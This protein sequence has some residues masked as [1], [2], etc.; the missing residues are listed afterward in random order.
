MSPDQW[1]DRFDGPTVERATSAFLGAVADFFPRSRVGAA[2]K[3]N[4]PGML[5]KMDAE[6]IRTM[7]LGRGSAG[8][9]GSDTNS[10][11]GAASP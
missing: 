8:S 11:A 5:A 1:A 7:R 4:L 6:I 3:A 2:I 10:P 9:G